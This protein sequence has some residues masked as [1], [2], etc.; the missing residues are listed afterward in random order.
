MSEQAAQAPAKKSKKG[1][2]IGVIAVVL[3]AGGGGGWYF[4]KGKN[5]DPQAAAEAE[6]KAAKKA[7]VFVPLDPFT[8]N[9]TGEDE[10]FAQ[11][12]I[13]LE[14]RDNQVSEDLKVVMPAV[15][16]K[17]LLLIS[18]KQARDLLT[19][20]G[21]E[22]LAVQI[23]EQTGRLLG[24]SPAPP[25]KTKVVKAEEEGEE[26]DEDEAEKAPKRKAKPNPVEQVHFAQFI[27]Q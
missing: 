5:A 15:R 16:N 9:L 1:L 26:A 12:A 19:V 24:W 7:R 25:K 13:T 4:M 2:L 27:V 21:K 10:R 6:Q 11:V 8:V 14:L 3:A 22:Q 18:S 20:Q 17:L 23:A